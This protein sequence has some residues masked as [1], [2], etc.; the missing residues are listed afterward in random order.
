M[1]VDILAFICGGNGGF[2]D[3]SVDGCCG[4]CGGGGGG[5]FVGCGRAGRI[6]C[7]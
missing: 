2:D 1:C 6:G 3:V 7:N 4:R 5:G